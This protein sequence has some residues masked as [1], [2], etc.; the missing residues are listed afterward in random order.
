MRWT[1]PIGVAA[2]SV[3]AAVTLA[4]CG[5][6][7][8]H[9]PSHQTATA[10]A[11]AGSVHSAAYIVPVVVEDLLPALGRYTLHT[12]RL[13]ARLTP[14]LAALQT[15]AAGDNLPAAES[16]WVTAHMTWLDLGQDDGAYGAFGQLGQQ[17]DGLADGYP[18]TTSNP[19][20]TGF[21]RIELDLWSKHDTAAAAKDT[22]V[23]RELVAKLT[24]RTVERDLPAQAVGLDSWVLRPHEILED[25]LRDS[26]S[27]DDDYG[28]DTD[29]ASL[30][31]D[32][33]ATREA[34][35]LL[36]PV[37]DTRAA[38]IV[39]EATAELTALDRA[40]KAAGDPMAG[41][42]LQS[43][44]PRERQQID[45]DTGAAVETIAPV[46]ELLQI[47]APGT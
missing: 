30:L 2:A 31:A 16:E 38:Y 36:A 42:N 18:G 13:I 25:A 1:W 21:H 10:T 15:D 46:S 26:L 14:Q 33:S 3:C 11:K 28:S 47:Y 29:L 22:A 41:H 9:S 34:L 27:Q 23:L 12:E 7:A 39:P 35:D 4:G 8:S 17:I 45:A 5:A 19:D 32:V 24:P 20:F 43:L 6:T 37:I 40:I 44:P